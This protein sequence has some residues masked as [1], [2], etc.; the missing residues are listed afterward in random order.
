LE[1]QL[2]PVVTSLPSKAR[3]Y[4]PVRVHY[5]PLLE[6]RVYIIESDSGVVMVDAGWPSRAQAILETM[7][8]I[9]RTDLRLIFITHAHFDH[10]GSAIAIRRATGAPIAIHHADAA[11]MARGTTQ[12]GMVRSWGLLGKPLLPF[13]ERLLRPEPTSAD[14]HFHDG[15]RL[16]QFGLDAVALHTPGH[17]A[18]SCCLLVNGDA[19]FVGDLFSSR[20]RLGPQACYAQ[21]WARIPAGVQRVLAFEPQWIFPGHGKPVNRERFPRWAENISE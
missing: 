4:L 14:I 13:T 20:P 2:M 9:G 21:D 7:R 18:G 16:D 5:V 12:I 15:Y 3:T 11:A 19:I 1:N 8:Q 6:S 10:Y 17:T